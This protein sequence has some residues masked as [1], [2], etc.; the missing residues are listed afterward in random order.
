MTSVAL[1][2]L[3]DGLRMGAQL[4]RPRICSLVCAALL[5]M[6]ALA[7]LIHLN[8]LAGLAPD[9]ALVFFQALAL[10]TLL[11]LLPVG[12]LWLL[13]RR[14]RR[15]PW[16]FA[17]AFLWGGCIATAIALPLNTA[18]FRL[19][20]QWVAQNPDILWLLGPEAPVLLAAPISAPIAEEIVKGL[21]VV[22]I[23]WLL[24]AEYI[25]VREGIVY[26]GLVGA[27][28]NWF[29]AALYVA[30][31]YAESGVPPYGLQLGARYA[32]LGLGGHAMLTGMFGAFLGLALQT[33][34][35][36][37]RILAPPFG[38]LLAIAAHMINNALPL[39]SVLSRIAAGDPPAQRELLPEPGFFDAFASDSLLE[40]ILF[41]PF[42][43]IAGL[44]LWR[45]SVRERR[46]IGDELADEATYVVSPKEYQDI[47]DDP[48]L[49][50][51]RIDPMRPRA[52]AAL[53]NAQHE[54]GLRKRRAREEGNDPH[55]DHIAAGW[56]E[57]IRRLR[58]SMPA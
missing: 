47:L 10:S 30:Q 23:F 36:W 53:V 7:I 46:V 12:L 35:T 2:S 8:L 28:F 1:G 31:G 21:G 11:S 3:Q 43:L 54:L 14:E 52:S 45:I 51:R 15:S 16:L 32:L 57:D 5:A 6:L 24:R 27:G 9:V 56:R 39:I 4:R 38:L 42:L 48:A 13:E 50:T 58:P 37:V 44:A 19:V 26:G 17:A 41:L 40:L 22:V 33:R 18:F 55:N 25:G 20:D 49:Q 34:R 29:E